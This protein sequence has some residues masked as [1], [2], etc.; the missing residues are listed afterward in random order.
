MT[1]PAITLS[2]LKYRIGKRIINCKLIEIILTKFYYI[3]ALGMPYGYQFLGIKSAP[4]V[5]AS[6]PGEDAAEDDL[7]VSMIRFQFK[8][9]M[10]FD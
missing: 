9:L 6:F 5:V 4:K 3:L 7:C 10:N 8:A 2:A 1:S